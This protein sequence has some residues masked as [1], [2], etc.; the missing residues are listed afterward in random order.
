MKA[1]LVTQSVEMV[2]TSNMNNVKMETPMIMTVAIL[3]VQLNK[4]GNVLVVLSLHHKNAQQY[5]EIQCFMEMKHVMMETYVISMGKNTYAYHHYSCSSTCKIENGF[6]CDT[7][8]YTCLP[9]CGDGYYV[10]GEACEDGNYVSNDG[11]NSLC[12]ARET[13]WTCSGGS[14]T[15]KQTCSPDCGDSLLKG[16]ETCDDGN[17][18]N[19]DG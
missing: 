13:G 6:T 12:K 18:N 1:L 4:V 19:L 9:T 11:C 8:G 14:L 10:A 5:V 7:F 17:K 16:S 15:T 2:I 3:D